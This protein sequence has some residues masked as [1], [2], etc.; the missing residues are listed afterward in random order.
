MLVGQARERVQLLHDVFWMVEGELQRGPVGA[1]LLRESHAAQLPAQLAPLK[2]DCQPHKK[3]INLMDYLNL[4]I[5]LAL[6]GVSLRSPF[7]AQQASQ[8]AG[9]SGPGGPLCACSPAPS[10]AVDGHS[11]QGATP[12]PCCGVQRRGPPWGQQRTLR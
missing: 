10:M 11:P 2:Q 4:G 1:G 12:C 3:I 9:T 8:L 5:Y 7:A 6:S